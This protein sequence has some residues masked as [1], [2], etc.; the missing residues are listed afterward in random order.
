MPKVLVHAAGRNIGDPWGHQPGEI[1]SVSPDS[2]DF[3]SEETLPTFWRIIVNGVTVDQLR[4]LTLPQITDNTGQL[5]LV[6]GLVTP[7]RRKEY[8]LDTTR[9]PGA[10]LTQLNTTGTYTIN[11]G[12]LSTLRNALRRWRDDAVFA[13]F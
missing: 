3:G 6:N 11:V 10:I 8:R 13:G 12:S 1:I 9:I 7:V 2:F 5:N 4:D